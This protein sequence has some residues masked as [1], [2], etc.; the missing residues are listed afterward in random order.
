MPPTTTR[1][2]WLSFT[3]EVNPF[4]TESV[5]VLAAHELIQQ[6]NRELDDLLTL[7]D[8]TVGHGRYPYKFSTEGVGFKVFWSPGQA[9]VL[10]EIEG[11]GCEQL[12]Q[13]GTMRRVVE[14]ALERLTRVDIAT[15]IETKTTP[16]DF[17]EQRT[18]KRHKSHET[19]V[20]STGTTVYIGSRK[21]DRYCRV[22]RYAEP[23][24][25]ADRLRVECVFRGHQAIAL[26]RTWLDEG[27]DETAARVGNQ[28]GWYHPDWE[29]HSKE[30]IK[31][32]RPDRKTHNRMHWYK[33]QVMPALRGMVAS[34]HLPSETLIRDLL[35]LPEGQIEAIL[36]V[37]TSASVDVAK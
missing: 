16:Q 2:D 12:E 22:Y 24:P 9:E 5:A 6:V 33:T 27:N 1:L 32:W 34:G 31:A 3:I 10:V 8:A 26:A 19:A 18:N 20:S 17:T 11:T 13:A 7:T 15:D 25:R 4:L 36:A 14:L 21:S 35:P 37:L 23:H 28:Y 30:K 29:P